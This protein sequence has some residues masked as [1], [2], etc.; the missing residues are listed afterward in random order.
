MEFRLP[1]LGEGMAEAEVVRW[2]VAEGGRVAEDEPLVEV[3]T[4]K[5]LVQI[6]SPAAGVVVRHGAREGER[7]PVG[8]VLAVIEA[9]PSADAGAIVGDLSEPGTLAV[10]D[11]GGAAQPPAGGRRLAS[12]ATRRL[13]RDLGVDLDE[14]RGTGPDGRVTPDDVR[15]AA[16]AAATAAAAVPAGAHAAAPSPAPAAPG[17][18]IPLRGL[19]R[20]I[21][22][23]M[24]QA[25]RAVPQVTVVEEA[26]VTELVRLRAQLNDQLSPER[27]GY[28]PFFAAAALRALALHPILNASLDGDRE[29]IVLHPH[30]NLGVAVD[31]PEGLMVAVLPEAEAFGVREL[32]RALPPLVEAARRREL[33]PE[34]LR[35]STFT[36]TSAGSVGGL[37]ATPIVN[38][39]EVAILG[40]HRIF[41]KLALRE[42]QVEPRHAVYLSLSFD[43]RAL[44]G[45]EASRYLV[46]LA[47]LLARP[48]QLLWS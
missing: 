39:P 19:R 22:E 48:L 8:G 44:D 21:A 12:P 18:R 11:D 40:V 34:R 37:F 9:A 14:V 23:R 30:V 29:E 13:A 36:I 35:G 20:R 43:H 28:L 45:A 2:L 32:A 16:R 4:D 33:P 15:Q 46:D 3:E 41:E 27:V 38:A 1:D 31:T 10:E 6:P 26:D 7:V 17:E 47:R 25:H 5:A 24:A 42:G